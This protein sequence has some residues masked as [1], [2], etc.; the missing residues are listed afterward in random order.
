MHLL[1][2]SSFANLFFIQGRRRRK[3][4]PDAPLE[5]PLV[6]LMGE[7]SAG[8]K[9]HLMESLKWSKVDKQFIVILSELRVVAGAGVLHK[10]LEN[11]F[12][13]PGGGF[14]DS[15]LSSFCG[16]TEKKP[17]FLSF[18][19]EKADSKPTL[20]AGSL[21]EKF[22]TVQSLFCGRDPVEERSARDTESHN[23][24]PN[25]CERQNIAY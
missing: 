10:T 19:W 16:I 17:R 15:L 1:F 3:R 14:F 6:A 8:N 21:N 12:P 7:V 24:C 25:I 13:L 2:N 20:P 18:L 23:K 22:W 4:S 11:A 5:S 9:T